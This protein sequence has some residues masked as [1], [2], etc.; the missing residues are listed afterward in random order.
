M[1]HNTFRVDIA[2]PPRPPQLPGYPPVPPVP[3]S[4]GGR[5]RRW[6]VLVAAAAVGAVVAAGAAALITTQSR[7]SAATSA[8][9]PST[10]TVPAPTPAAPVPLPTAQADQQTCRQGWIPAGE[11]IDS[12]TAALNV[13][14]KGMKIDDPAVQANP[15]YAAAVIRAAGFYRQ[16]ASA[17]DGQIA[18]GATPVLREAAHAA[19]TALRALGDSVAAPGEIN[20]NVGEIA[21][22]A[23]AQVGVL[24]QRLAP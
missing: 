1:S 11:A 21:N 9:A 16:A 17:L 23:S 20:G 24:C 19:V 6:P 12:A 10:V 7:E 18:P 2:P 5:W 4:G 3:P 13:L 14:P 15:Q 8:P 22:A